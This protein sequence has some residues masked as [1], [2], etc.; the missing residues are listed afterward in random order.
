M[1]PAGSPLPRTPAQVQA[2]GDALIA[3]GVANYNATLAAIEALTSA[4]YVQAN[5]YGTLQYT[6]TLG[7]VL[8]GWYF[9]QFFPTR[10]YVV[11]ERDSIK[12]VIPEVKLSAPHIVTFLNGAPDFPLGYPIAGPLA[13]LSFP[14]AS[15]PSLPII[16]LN[17]AA[18][19]PADPDLV[20]SIA[21]FQ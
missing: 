13:N 1:L 17:P 11:T 9:M 21:R 18:V 4:S 12:F 19:F 20:S 8:N 5:N 7:Y 16:M 15:Y 3:A 6:V 10:Q 14:Y 2:A